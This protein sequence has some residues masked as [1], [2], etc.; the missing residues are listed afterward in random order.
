VIIHEDD[1]RL[2]LDPAMCDQETLLP[3]L[4]PY[5][6]D[7]MEH[8][9]VTSKVNSFKYNNPENIKPVTG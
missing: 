3:L 9:P 4:K 1:Y 8:Y 7:E 5:P 2:W 6:S